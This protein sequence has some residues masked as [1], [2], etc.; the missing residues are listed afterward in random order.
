M[1]IL[2]LNG[3]NINLIGMREPEIYGKTTYKEL[4]RL[5]KKEADK[6]NFNIEFFQSNFE[7]ELIEKVQ[8]SKGIFNYIIANLGA[9]THTSIALRD[10]LIYSEIPVVEVHMSNI[11]NRE[12]FRHKSYI[13]DIAIG[14]ITGFKEYSYIMALYAI[15]N[16][17]K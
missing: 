3:P 2:V 8:K 1:K 17:S 16:I 12:K 10:A 15:S 4:C 14:V 11:F 13:S 7:G 6:L 5:I 9:L